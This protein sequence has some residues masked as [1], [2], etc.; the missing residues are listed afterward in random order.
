MSL[1]VILVLAAVGLSLSGCAA[2]LADL[3]AQHYG[4]EAQIAEAR[5]K[6]AEEC[7]PVALAKAESAWSF[8][9]IEFREGDVDRAEQHLGD[10]RTYLGVALVAL[11][12][13]KPLAEAVAQAS[14]PADG[15]GSQKDTDGDGLVDDADKC[16]T[17]PEDRDGFQDED[18]C[19]EPDNDG[20]GF[21]DAK[22]PCPN[23]AEDRDGFQDHDGC[24]DLDN[25]GDGVPDAQDHCVDAPETPNGYADTDGCPDLAPKYIKI[26]G[27]RIVQLTAISFR[28]RSTEFWGESWRVL[29]E[30]AA[31]MND[32][33]GVRIQVEG[34]TDNGG[35]AAESQNLSVGMAEAAKA[36]LVEQGVEP[37]R[38]DVVGR[39]GT[40]P[41]DTNR[42]PEG[43]ERNNRV[44]IFILS[45]GSP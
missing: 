43:R 1:R 8:A 7:A 16:P 6:G 3:R 45:L 37:E 31:Y 13:C 11:K 20:D 10:G 19:P 38:V 32:Y 27:N 18:G 2:N 21:P 33:S 44:E 23:E 39:G 26:E 35:S 30:V 22:D 41:I 40:M 17:K 9:A 28:G 25:D 24:P 5:T 15:A 42:T 14:R 12:D 34:H 29:N 36:Y 4:L